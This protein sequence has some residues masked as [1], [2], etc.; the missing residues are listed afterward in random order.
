ME[1][2]SAT[3]RSI[4]AKLKGLRAG[5]GLGLAALAAKSG[6][7]R[8]ALWRI[9]NARV[10]ATADQLACLAHAHGTTLSQ[11]LHGIEHEFE[12]VVRRR[13]QELWTDPF[14]GLRRRTVSPG[15]PQLPGRVFEC[16]L[17]A[18]A[19]FT[20]VMP[21][22]ARGV[23]HLVMLEGRLHVTAGGRTHLVV[24]VDCLRYRPMGTVTFVTEGKSEAWFLLF[25]A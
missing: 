4:A 10:G 11:L 1:T 25:E 7:S 16:E 14:S 21:A 22:G 13:H 2:P 24:P 19:T 18:N 17:P 15:G 9:E 6:I 3:G 20:E 12:A 23:C 8:S 5:A